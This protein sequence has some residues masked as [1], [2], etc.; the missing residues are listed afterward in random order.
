VF[1]HVFCLLS[2]NFVCDLVAVV[3]PALATELAMVGTFQHSLM[4][5][6]DESAAQRTNCASVSSVITVSDCISVLEGPLRSSVFLDLFPC[7]L[8]SWSYPGCVVHF[9]LIS[10]SSSLVSI[11]SSCF[12]VGL[13]PSQSVPFSLFFA[14]PIMHSLSCVRVVPTVKCSVFAV[15]I[16]QSPAPASLYV[17]PCS[18]VSLTL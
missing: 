2:Q 9:L 8:L 6:A 14:T 5:D 13:N 10:F 7:C 3:L 15:T 17:C 1:G 11:L 18:L 4:S 16:F 12:E